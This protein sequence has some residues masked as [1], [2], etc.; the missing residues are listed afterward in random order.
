[1]KQRHWTKELSRIIFWLLLAAILG[2]LSGY[3]F[4]CLFIVAVGYI[5]W[6]LWQVKRID[7]WLRQS[8]VTDPPETLGFWGDICDRLYRLQRKHGR[9]KE[10]LRR[11]LEQYH[12]SLASL[13]DAVVLVN[14]QDLITWCNKAALHN[15]G[16]HFPEDE[17]QPLLNFL[18]EPAFVEFYEKG[19]YRG[20]KIQIQ[21]PVDQERVLVVQ[22]SR[23]GDDNRLVFARDITEVHR[24]EQ[25]RQDFVSN[26]SHELRTPLTVLMGYIDNFQML[27]DTLPQLQ[28]PLV[29][30]EQHA[31][32]M[33]ILL[34]DLLELSRLETL[35]HEMHKTVVS[36]TQLVQLVCEEARNSKAGQGREVQ[37]VCADDLLIYGKQSELHSAFLN[38]I[39]N[40]LKYSDMGDVVAVKLCHTDKGIS[41]S[42]KD[43]GLGIDPLHIP[44]LTERFYRADPSRSNERGG[45]GLGLAIV[46]RVL[47]HHDSEL[48][49]ESQLGK[50]SRFSCIIPIH[51]LA[52][53]VDI[54]ELSQ[55]LS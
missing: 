36:L 9:V 31:K 21:A 34:R 52:K 12:D 24:L 15:L 1:M 35:P 11:E 44:R 46:K 17:G 39:I 2:T 40:A 53:S 37:L 50:G 45:T 23:F 54:G 48:N 19:D 41:F 38:L 6:T 26:V 33:E 5:I 22:I 43:D 7:D 25:M 18:R 51:R 27:S 47:A 55:K 32:R 42:V 4:E 8:D 13:S 30:M 16:L 14:K 20:S 28:K 3:L 49:I 10:S 29:Q